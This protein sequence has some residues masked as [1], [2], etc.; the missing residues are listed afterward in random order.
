MAIQILPSGG[1]TAS[2][3]GV[4]I[5][6]GNLISGGISGSSEFAAGEATALKRDKALFA[7]SEVISSYIAGLAAGLALGVSVGTPNKQSLNW[8]YSFTLQTYELRNGS[9]PL[10]PLPV[11]TSGTNSGVGDFA[12]TDIFPNATKVASAASLTDSGVLIETAPLVRHGS[13]AHAS[14]SLSGDNR[15]FLNALFRWIASNSEV[16]TRTASVASAVTTKTASAP[17]IFSLPTAATAA[18]NPTTALSSADL[19]ILVLNSFTSSITFN[20]IATG[21]DSNGEMKLEVNSVT[22]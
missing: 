5:P 17:I 20:L 3:N 18:T 8:T 10:A 22:S 6:V 15:S 13:P 9:T 2:F 19:D 1:G 11:P 7:I 14:L 16:P 4:F 12:L 21:P